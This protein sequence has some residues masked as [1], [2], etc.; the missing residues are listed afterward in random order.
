MQGVIIPMGVLDLVAENFSRFFHRFGIEGLHPRARR[1]KDSITVIAGASRM[2]SVRGLK[3][4]PQTAN[5][6]PAKSAPKWRFHFFKQKSLLTLIDLF[7]RFQQEHRPDFR[8][9]C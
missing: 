8:R 9:P 5:V 4:S 3:A 6:S 2:S 7:H 1:K